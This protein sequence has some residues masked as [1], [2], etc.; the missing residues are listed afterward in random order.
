MT[1]TLLKVSVSLIANSCKV[2]VVE[3]Q[4]KKTAKGYSCPGFRIREDALMSIES[5][6]REDIH[7]ISVYYTY[8]L[9][10]DMRNAVDMLTK[11]IKEKT[12]RMYEEMRVVY[13][14]LHL[15]D[16]PEYIYRK[17]DD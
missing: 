13:N 4:V 5:R 9:E 12:E 8:C 1:A 6:M 10:E 17:S 11:N 14:S 3:M 7:N 16:S 2:K 15:L